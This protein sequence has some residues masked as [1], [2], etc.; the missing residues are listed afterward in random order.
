MSTR[1]WR[2]GTA[3]SCH[4]P[5]GSA[6]AGLLV[7]GARQLCLDCHDDL[8]AGGAGSTHA[9][10]VKQDCTVCH[11]P[12][13]SSQPALLLQKAGSL[14]LDCHLKVR[15]EIGEA[16][17]HDVVARGECL[18]CH[19]PHLSAQ[20]GLLTAAADGPL[21]PLPRRD[22]STAPAG[23]SLHAPAARGRLP[24]LP[25]ASRRRVSRAS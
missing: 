5:H 19:E 4:A 1:R 23:G 9:P 12:H 21:Q 25:P 15:R 10:F 11:D 6:E 3:P 24:G 2:A 18:A 17:P 8:D 20:P 16:Y 22:C 14:C 13:S 7:T